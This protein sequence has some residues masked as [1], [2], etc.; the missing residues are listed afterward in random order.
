MKRAVITTIF[1]G[2]IAGT[3]CISAYAAE[4]ET[5]EAPGWTD[6]ADCAAG[7]LANWQDRLSK[8]DRS[9][10]M[11][12]M[13]RTQSDEYKATAIALYQQDSK[14]GA[15]AA[16][17]VVETYIQDSLARFAAM[18]KAGKLESFIDE[19]PQTDDSDQD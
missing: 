18:D 10:E 8:P 3:A 12:A 7:Y 16:R 11:S 1:A 5:D 9:R 13:I 2:A 17:G 4:S 19:C 14:T 15:D 6:Y